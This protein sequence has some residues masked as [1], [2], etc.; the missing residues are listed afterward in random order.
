MSTDDFPVVQEYAHRRLSEQE[1]QALDL[2]T[3]EE[4]ETART[5]VSRLHVELGHSDPQGMIDSLRKNTHTDS[6]L[7]LPKS[8]VAVR[9]KRV[10][11]EDYV[12]W[13]LEFFMNLTHVFKFINLSGDIQC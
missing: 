12:Q 10:R 7:L 9:V 8:S 4:R 3:E 1:K 6:S 5:I 13:M 11:D 2:A